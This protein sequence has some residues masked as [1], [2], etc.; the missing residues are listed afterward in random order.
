MDHR[1]GLSVIAVDH[2]DNNSSGFTERA[3]CDAVV[4]LM[5]SFGPCEPAKDNTIGPIFGVLPTVR[6]D[7]INSDM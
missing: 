2:R 7:G 4:T 3:L 1:D 5:T 6:L